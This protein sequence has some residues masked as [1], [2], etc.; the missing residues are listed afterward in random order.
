MR[1]ARSTLIGTAVAM[2]LFGREGAVRAEMAAGDQSQSN[3]TPVQEVTVTGIRYSLEQSIE[4]K[5]AAIN[6]V[7][8]VTAEDIGKL[9]DKNVADALQ[10]IPGVTISGD[11]RSRGADQRSAGGARGLHRPG[12]RSRRGRLQGTRARQAHRAGRDPLGA[13]GRSVVQPLLQHQLAELSQLL[14]RPALRAHRMR[15][16]R[17]RARGAL[18][19][20]VA[21]PR[22]RD[23]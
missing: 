22:A 2:A 6:V 8:V 13:Y 4:Q 5:R 19:Y 1:I 3:Q 16:R 12:P 11:Q 17:P 15:L 9:P 23:G 21:A 18:R 7:D 10:R 14:R 20:A